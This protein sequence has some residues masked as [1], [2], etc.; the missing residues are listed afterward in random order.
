MERGVDKT[1]APGM[2]V[3]Q[4]RVQAAVVDNVSVGDMEIESFSVHQQLFE[5]SPENHKPAEIDRL[6][7]TAAEHSGQ[8]VAG[9]VEVGID[10]SFEVGLISVDIPCWWEASDGLVPWLLAGL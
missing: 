1:A 8:D 7:W 4:L 3:E 2:K 6:A 5:Q 10:R 9:A